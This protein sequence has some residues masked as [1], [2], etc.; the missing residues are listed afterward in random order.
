MSPP[1]VTEASSQSA[2]PYQRHRQQQSSTSSLSH[3]SYL[4]YNNSF[5]YEP[6]Q[7]PA[8]AFASSSSDAVTPYSPS[9]SAR[10]PTPPSSGLSASSASTLSP[11]APEPPISAQALLLDVLSL[12]SAASPMSLSQSQG[13]LTRSN[14]PLLAA[15]H[16]RIRSAGST[17][18]AEREPASSSAG[19]SR[20]SEDRL[21][22]RSGPV[23]PYR[24]GPKLDT[25]DLSHK[26]I[27]ELPLE[28]VNELRDEVEKLALGYN[29]LKD[30][31]MH[32]V[33]LGSRLKYLN[34]RVN[35][36]TTFPAVVRRSLPLLAP[37]SRRSPG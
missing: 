3:G 1:P 12:R 18:S 10:N 13:P 22:A 34:I 29:L 31:P 5:S 37:F 4:P 36:L 35:L 7:T 15:G 16:Q 9:S 30:L 8:S 17:G 6:R 14:T 27:A 11:S 28:V 26:R 2:L 25:V 23:A 24:G 20:P 32:F 21:P 33:Q 19:S